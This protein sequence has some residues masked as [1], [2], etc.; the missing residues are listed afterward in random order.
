MEGAS[1]MSFVTS[2]DRKARKDHVC[3][4]CGGKIPKGFLYTVS[5]CVQ[6]REGFSD[7]WHVECIKEY[8]NACIAGNYDG[9]MDTWDT[10]ENGLLDEIRSKYGLEPK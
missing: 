8:D 5:F 7:K 10:W 9:G 6:D 4:A 1:D 2:T 3:C